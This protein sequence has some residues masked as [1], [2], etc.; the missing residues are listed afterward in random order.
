M[1]RRFDIQSEEFVRALDKKGCDCKNNCKEKCN[2]KK[3][4]DVPLERDVMWNLMLQGG[5]ETLGN[6]LGE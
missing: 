1:S 3:R 5:M 2:C 4:T 6:S